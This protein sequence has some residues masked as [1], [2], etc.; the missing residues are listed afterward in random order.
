MWRTGVAGLILKWTSP[1]AARDAPRYTRHGCV[2]GVPSEEVILIV[3]LSSTGL[4]FASAA[5]VATAGTPPA[6]PL[7]AADAGSGAIA[8]VAMAAADLR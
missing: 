7:G 4:D 6:A 8:T 5:A 2:V 1:P 3:S